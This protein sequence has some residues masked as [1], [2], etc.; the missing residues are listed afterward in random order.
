MHVN[1][2]QPIQNPRRNEASAA[3]AAAAAAAPSAQEQEQQKGTKQQQQQQQEQEQQKGTQQ[4]EQQKGTQ[5]Q[6]QQQQQQEQARYQQPAY[7]LH[8]P[9]EPPYLGYRGDLLAVL[10]NAMCN[11]PAVADAVA[12]EA[13]AVELVLGQVGVGVLRGG[14]GRMVSAMCNWP[15]VVEEVASEQ[16]RWSWCLGRWV[17]GCCVGEGG[18]V[19][20]N[21]VMGWFVWVERGKDGSCG[22]VSGVWF[23]ELVALTVDIDSFSSRCVCACVCVRACVR[24]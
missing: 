22:C 5:Q 20:C 17:W 21:L 10:A 4:Q 14:G 18:R 8:A 11:R 23:Q 1:T 6:Q 3:A 19:R 7:T 24:A 2:L 12:L 13:G 9:V 16:G 15:M